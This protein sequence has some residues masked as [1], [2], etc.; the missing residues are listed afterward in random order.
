MTCSSSLGP[1]LCCRA[2]GV[3]AWYAKSC[4]ELGHTSLGK[5]TVP[6]GGAALSSAKTERGSH[7]KPPLRQLQAINPVWWALLIQEENPSCLIR[8]CALVKECRGKSVR[9]QVYKLLLSPSFPKCYHFTEKAAPSCKRQIPGGD[10][11]AI[12]PEERESQIV[13]RFITTGTLGGGE[14]SPPLSPLTLVQ[15]W[16]SLLSGPVIWA[17]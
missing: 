4:L 16:M 8:K 5:A 17:H 7:G 6:Q 3:R 15:A 14:L 1:G 11:R 9:V 13:Y 2:P 12:I 10:P